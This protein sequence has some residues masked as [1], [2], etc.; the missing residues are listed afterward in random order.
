MNAADSPSSRPGSTVSRPLRIGSGAPGS[1][2]MRA[3]IGVSNRVAVS[4]SALIDLPNCSR[5][6]TA[7]SG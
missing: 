2:A 4:L 6:V 7:R 3:S 1:G 5:P